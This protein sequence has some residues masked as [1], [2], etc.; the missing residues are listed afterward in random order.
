MINFNIEKGLIEYYYCFDLIDKKNINKVSKLLDKSLCNIIY[1]KGKSC[2]IKKEYDNYYKQQVRNLE[3]KAEEIATTIEE[4]CK[5]DGSNYKSKVKYTNKDIEDIDYN[6]TLDEIDFNININ[7]DDDKFSIYLTSRENDLILQKLDEFYYILNEDSRYLGVE[8]I[9][10]IFFL[11]PIALIDS[12]CVEKN[13]YIFITAT[14]HSSGQLILK[15]SIDISNESSDK[16]YDIKIL[17]K[18]TAKVPNILLDKNILGYSS[19]IVTLEYAINMYNKHIMDIL[20]IRMKPLINKPICFE[21]IILG[22][23]EKMP[24][25]FNSIS[26]DM[27]E[28]LFFIVNRPYGYLNERN[29]EDYEKFIDSRY[30]ISRY[31]GLFSGTMGRTLTLYNKDYSLISSDVTDKIPNKC[32]L[33]STST[34]AII[35]LLLIKRTSY[36]HI[37]REV[38]TESCSIRHMRELQ[39]KILLAENYNF[40][41]LK[42]SFGSIKNLYNHLENNMTDFF[43][44]DELDRKLNLYTA[45]LNNEENIEKDRFGSRVS[46]MGV[47]VT[48]IFGISG[49]ER[50]TDV[51]YVNTS[52]IIDNLYGSGT[53]NELKMNIINF[54]NNFLALEN[55]SIDFI[56]WLILCIFV[57]IFF[58][59][60]KIVRSIKDVYEI[61]KYLIIEITRY[62]KNK[63][64]S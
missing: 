42:T 1:K 55:V 56:L 32:I 50:L 22:E 28:A 47:I 34:S 57:I 31:L 18:F 13:N 41:N 64:I 19:E 60:D 3:P 23:Y 21:N 35:K 43:P 17:D 58:Y 24:Q 63:F 2:F 27:K 46:L 10:D 30:N 37:I 61:L 54:K 6:G 5:R 7:F 45:I 4:S 29:K 14:L 25:N 9:L 8:N 16:L 15:Y 44:K 39:K 12:E 26:K 52:H 38:L 36:E 20:R 51:G 48:L 33:A 40:L 53:S 11:H 62:F 49:I 59:K